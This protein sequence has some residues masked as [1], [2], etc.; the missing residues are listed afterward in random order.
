MQLIHALSGADNETT[1]GMS[2]LRLWIHYARRPA[3]AQI[4]DARSHRFGAKA[5]IEG[6]CHS[7]PGGPNKGEGP[8]SD[9]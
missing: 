6:S 9:V 8:Y 3:A 7:L 4:R 5:A 1:G 2:E